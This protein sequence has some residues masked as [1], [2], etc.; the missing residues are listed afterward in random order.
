[1]LNVFFNNE[2]LAAEKKVRDCLNIPSLL[3]MEN[4]GRNCAEFILDNF[5]EVR[6]D[7]IIILTGKGNNAGD[8]FVA[9]R[10]LVNHGCR[11]S[12]LMLYPGSEIKGDAL[13]NFSVIK[14][15]KDELLSINYC[16]TAKDVEREIS[17]TDSIIIDAVFGVGFLGEPDSRI[18]LIFEKINSLE[19]IV[20]S[21][22]VPSGLHNCIQT[23][24]AVSSDYTL[25]IGAKKFSSMFY[26][27]KE[28]SGSVE[29]ID[30]GVPGDSFDKYNARK[31]FE[32]EAT[33]I[34]DILPER[35]FDAHKYTSGKV[36]I[37]AGSR[38][39]SG[40]ACMSS[41]S[42]MRTGSGAVFLGHPSSLGDVFEMKLTEV[43]KLPL[44]E[45]GDQS[46]SLESLGQMKEKLEWADAVLLGPGL[47]RNPETMQVVR[48][49]LK[50]NNL[51]FVI[52][53]DA[54]RALKN[55]LSALK[56]RRVILTPHIGEF[57]D[58]LNVDTEEVKNNF[59]EYAFEFA[60]Q[61][62][63]VLLLKNAPSVITDGNEFYINS[64]GHQNL[65]TAGSG[66]VL[67]GI[68]VSL[69]SQGMSLMDSAIAGAYIHGRCGD[70]LFYEYGTNS[71]IA[72]DLIPMIPVV[73]KS[74]SAV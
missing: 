51:N 53:A 20:V 16:K 33:D 32:I 24:T 72:G 45:T 49:I 10:H 30:M 1:M 66:D 41:L 27:G 3:L 69:L 60:K 48:K 21:I 36:F 11:V 61:H 63:I 29:L 23:S 70:N 7:E 47:S 19:N 56:N 34:Q 31:I 74:L 12:V 35:Q 62:K 39:L 8:G 57:A 50:D 67:S 42:A 46:L 37:L 58:L 22:D 73:K 14:N 44:P 43:M 28:H 64:T 40:A 54:L 15:Y 2:I 59:Y 65:A 38:G 52:D 5:A 25:Q 26:Y 13:V 9:A 71:T 68:T 18:K 4:A 6:S 55:N 17:D